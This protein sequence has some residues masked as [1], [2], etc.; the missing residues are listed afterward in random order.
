M[1][2]NKKVKKNWSNEDLKVLVWIVGK[3]CE[4]KRI[5]DLHNGIVLLLIYRRRKQIGTTFPL[6]FLVLVQKCVCLNGYLSK[7]AKSGTKNGKKKNNYYFR[8]L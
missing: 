5:K 3:Y 2:K 1:L 7:R 4:K 6:L 8:N